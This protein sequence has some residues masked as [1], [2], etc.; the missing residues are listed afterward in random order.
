MFGDR[1][2]L[3]PNYWGASLTCRFVVAVY[4]WSNCK[5]W[6]D[7]II[8]AC[9]IHLW[10]SPVF[11]WCDQVKSVIDATKLKFWLDLVKLRWF[12]VIKTE[13]KFRIDV[14]IQSNSV[15][16]WSSQILIWSDQ[17]EIMIWILTLSGQIPIWCTDAARMS[18]CDLMWSSQIL[19]LS[20]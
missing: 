13:D 10:S 8:S 3:L 5:F 7:R 20:D 14:L 12:D 4:W 16:M 6:S 2:W 1:W 17:I 11:I 15:L 18:N 9:D 19:I